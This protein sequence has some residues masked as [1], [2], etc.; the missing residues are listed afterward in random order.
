MKKKLF[1]LVIILIFTG[2]FYHCGGGRGGSSG[3][4]GENSF[5][6]DSAATSGDKVVVT[7]GSQTVNFIYANNSTSIIFP[8]G[9]ADNTTGTITRKFF[10]SDT[11]VTWSLMAEVL[12]WA[13]D[14]G[15]IVE[16]G[17]VHNELSA[18]TVKYGGKE[19]L[20]LDTNPTNMKISYNTTT[21]T[22]SVASG[23]EDYPVTNV[24]WY[25]AIM[26]CNWLTEMRDGNTTNVAYTGI[27]ST[28]DHNETIADDSKSGYRLL[29]NTEWEY[30]GRYYGT[31]DD[32]RT[33]L[34]S[35]YGTNPNGLPLTDGYF[36][37]PGNYSSGST[38]YYN[39]TTDTHPSNGVVDG[40]DANDQV[41][42]YGY[43]WDGSWVATGVSGT[44]DVASKNANTLGLYDMSGNV[45]EWCFDVYATSNR[46]LW[47]GSWFGD[48]RD[49]AVSYW[50]NTL[51]SSEKSYIG[52]R[53][54]RT[55]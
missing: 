38:T 12:Q 45:S 21:H 30:A 44:A 15:K 50:S 52:F 42:V 26:F 8:T 24:S 37:T 35:R 29:T 34:I 54:A 31:S 36:W 22:F 14:N 48:A 25:G 28:W 2:F 51:A 32:G 6:F 53:I 5:T 27:D 11:E 10:L 13:Y 39:D 16:T 1:S 7:V 46:M 33:D 3:G 55:K 20:D 47:G 43:Y 41:A 19:L 49:L 40:K 4:G 23:C 17:G 9:T 18:T